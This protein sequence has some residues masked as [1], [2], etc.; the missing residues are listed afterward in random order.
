MSER[1]QQ[2]QQQSALGV[3]PG[4]VRAVVCAC[5]HH[6]L[7]H[8]DLPNNG[9]RRSGP[10]QSIPGIPGMDLSPDRDLSIASPIIFFVCSSPSSYMSFIMS[11]M[12]A[13]GLACPGRFHSVIS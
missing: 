6:I 13:V 10:A 2:R 3:G 4:V 1:E 8:N 9:R 5:I 12:P 11:M 7:A